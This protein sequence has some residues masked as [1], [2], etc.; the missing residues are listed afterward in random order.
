MQAQTVPPTGDACRFRLAQR[1]YS[2]ATLSDAITWL[3]QLI[4]IDTTNPPGN[5]RR[6]GQIHSRHS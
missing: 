6:G 1:R 3:Q 5:E 2:S 4:R